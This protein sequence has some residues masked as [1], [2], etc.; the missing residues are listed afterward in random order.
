[1][2]A[3]RVL[4]PPSVR[5]R[6]SSAYS[7]MSG[8]TSDSSRSVWTTPDPSEPAH[9]DES[10]V[11]LDS[12]PVRRAVELDRL[13]GNYC[14]SWLT[15]PIRVYCLQLSARAHGVQK[16]DSPSTVP[17]LP[18]PLGRIRARDVGRTLQSPTDSKVGW[19]TTRQDETSQ[20]QS[21]TARFKQSATALK[22]EIQFDTETGASSWH[23]CST[24][25]PLAPIHTAD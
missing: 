15:H 14:G 13:T 5:S 25:G 4:K 12:W 10:P 22:R 1:M 24:I 21:C 20:L 8:A 9:Y 19:P 2:L 6:S 23:L 11:E 7:S 16:C 3:M 17:I 18:E